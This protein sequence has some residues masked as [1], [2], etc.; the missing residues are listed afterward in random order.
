MNENKATPTTYGLCCLDGSIVRTKVAVIGAGIAG[1]GCCHRLRVEHGLSRE[2]V[3]LLEARDRI[4]GRVHT[5]YLP[6]TGIP[7]DAGASWIH[8]VEGSPL[9]HYLEHVPSSVHPHPQITSTTGVPPRQR[10]RKTKETSE[11]LHRPKDII[12][13]DGATKS[14]VPPKKTNDMQ[15]LF[16]DLFEK[17]ENEAQKRK[18]EAEAE[19]Q[20]QNK[21]RSNDSLGIALREAFE[22]ERKKDLGMEEHELETRL[23]DFFL[24]IASEYCGGPM[25]DHSLSA[26]IEDEDA[27]P[28]THLFL[29]EYSIITDEL[30]HQAQPTLRLNQQVVHID[31]HHNSCS[32][33]K[34]LG[35]RSFFLCFCSCLFF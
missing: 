34:P 1:L 6:K 2:E 8:G 11:G 17:V 9:V 13:F 10:T 27:F 23:Y 31:Y 30:F 32:K 5:C 33:T 19:A 18:E 16:L 15:Q 25:D 12:I 14:F 20:Q 4:G 26:W 3:L 29:S 24:H 28:G 7:V 22:E 21:E 35:I